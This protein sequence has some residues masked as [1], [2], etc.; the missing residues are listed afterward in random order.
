MVV[1]VHIYSYFIY[2]KLIAKIKYIKKCKIYKQALLI[3]FEGSLAAEEEER[4]EGRKCI[5]NYMTLWAF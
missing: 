4:Q 1:K 2:L 5:Y 3:V